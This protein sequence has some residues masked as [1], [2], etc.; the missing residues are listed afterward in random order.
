MDLDDEELEAT[1]KMKGLNHMNNIEKLEKFI[2]D[3]NEFKEKRDLNLFV[4]NW[5][6][7]QALENL[8]QEN[9]ELK[10][11]N[12]KLTYARNWYFEHFTSQA[13]TAEQ[14]HK[15]LRF[16]YIPKSKVKEMIKELEEK[17][18]NNDKNIFGYGIYFLQELL[19]EGE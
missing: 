7:K 4:M 17:Q 14:L 3:F 2:N 18:N 15:I 19:E 9:K 1:R 8:I 13:C 10:E 6:E 11:E 16:D 5:E 12:E